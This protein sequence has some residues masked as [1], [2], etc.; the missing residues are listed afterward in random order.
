MKD[1][2]FVVEAL[3]GSSG[4]YRLAAGAEPELFLSGP[5]LIGVA[6]DPRGGLVVCSNDS[7]YRLPSL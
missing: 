6:F 3:A 2:D 7:A 1:C 5:G 4:L